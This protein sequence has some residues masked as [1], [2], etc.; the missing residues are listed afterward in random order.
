LGGA[1]HSWWRPCCDVKNTAWSSI[2]IRARSAG[3]CSMIPWCRGWF[4][5]VLAMANH[6]NYLMPMQ[7]Q[8]QATKYCQ[9]RILNRYR[10]PRCLVDV[11][12]D[13]CQLPRT[14]AATLTP[15]RHLLTGTRVRDFPR[16]FCPV[17]ATLHPIHEWHTRWG[18]CPRTNASSTSLLR[19]DDQRV[20]STC[21]LLGAERH[22]IRAKTGAYAGV[23]HMTLSP[24]RTQARAIHKASSVPDM[25]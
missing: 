19:F 2:G 4:A 21:Q 9:V 23:R 8:T 1:R 22:S 20:V 15:T 24:T 16:S 18:S 14:N 25:K 6:F 5:D 7:S 10:T 13:A 12:G 17:F 3:S 11:M